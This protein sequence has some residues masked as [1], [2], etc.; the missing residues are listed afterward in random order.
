MGVEGSCWWTYDFWG[1]ISFMCF[2]FTSVF[3]LK[4][5]YGCHSYGSM[6]EYNFTSKVYSVESSKGREKKKVLQNLFGC[7]SNALKGV[8]PLVYLE[9]QKSRI[10]KLIIFL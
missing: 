10:N 8:G 6:M 2:F 7:Q 1:L 4:K 3:F 5:K 9:G